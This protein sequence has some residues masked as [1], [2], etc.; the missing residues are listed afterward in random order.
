MFSLV[1]GKWENMDRKCVFAMSKQ[2]QFVYVQLIWK[3]V[4]LIRTHMQTPFRELYLRGTIQ[5]PINQSVPWL[6]W[7][8][9]GL[10]C[11]T[12]LS[13]I[14]QLYRGGQ[15][16]WWKKPKH[17]QRTTDLPQVT[18][19]LYRI[20]LYRVHLTSAGFELTTLMV[21]GTD[22]IGC[23]KFIYHMITILYDI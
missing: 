10:W 5:Q 18:D 3:I 6:C 22:F 20:M 2:R 9:L 21:K 1:Y 14:F 15:F 7:I 8:G 11:S 19:K 23:W 13:T 12:P 4:Y 16:Y 17:P